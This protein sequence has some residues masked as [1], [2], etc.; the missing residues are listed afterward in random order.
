MMAKQS[1]T[2]SRNHV[3]AL[4]L[5]CVDAEAEDIYDTKFY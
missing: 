5:L 3:G 1:I 4:Q 2:E